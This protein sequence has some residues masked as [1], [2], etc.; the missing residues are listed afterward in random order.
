MER[1]LDDERLQAYHEKGNK[2]QRDKQIP[3]ATHHIEDPTLRFE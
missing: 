3:K 1:L 2:K